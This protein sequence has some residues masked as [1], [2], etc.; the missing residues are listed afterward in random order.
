MLCIKC[1]KEID[2]DSA[3]CKYCGK[4]Q[5]AETKKALKRANGTGSVYK[6]SGRRRKPWIA[7]VSK[8][9]G[10]HQ[11][12]TPIGTFETKTD[13]LNALNKIDVKAIPDAYN[14]TVKDFY[15]IWSSKH[16]E[17]I[18]KST[19]SSYKTAWTYLE[20]YGALKVRSL[21]SRHVQA[22]IDEAIAK[23]NGLSLCKKIKIVAGKI[24]KRAMQEDVV[25]KDC[26]QFAVL[27]KETT[28]EKNTFSEKEI[29]TI[30]KYKDVKT[31]QIIL[32]L[33]YLGARPEELFE[34]KPKDVHLKDRYIIGGSKTEAGRNRIMP[35]H[36]D[37]YDFINSWLNESESNQYLLT[38]SKGNKINLD[39]FRK[40]EF[41]P[42]LE[43]IGILEK[44]VKPRRLTPYSARHTFIS[45]MVKNDAKAE[46][47]Q[48][49]VGH[50]QYET[51]ID[52][53]THITEED[54]K[55]LVNELDEH[56]KF[57]C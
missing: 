35:I 19:V 14:L 6:L 44:D 3:Y 16:Y 13:A 55:L 51:T 25:S 22:A 24:C 1:K 11:E 5:V 18:D 56:L 31:A 37:I 42:F 8:K 57:S 47:L 40:R 10:S 32:V 49:I 2:P 54:I 27:P 36:M 38:N 15:E 9:V 48:R 17:N 33:L 41:Y 30:W 39:N 20:P 50:E 53:Y 21:T 43:E 28:K 26:S 34:T 46:F 12:K 29:K 23:G 45:N 7:V 4:K 52:Y